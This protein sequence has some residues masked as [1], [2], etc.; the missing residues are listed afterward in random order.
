M[1]VQR[2]SSVAARRLALVGD[3]AHAFPPIGAQGLNL[4][5]RDVAAIVAEAKVGG[6]DVLAR[7]AASRRA[8][9]AMRT[10]GVGLLNSVLLTPWTPV[11][12]ARGLGLAALSAF[13]PLRKMA[14]R[15]GLNPFLAR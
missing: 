15:E 3:A 4:G 12:A 7:Y 14:M 6:E 11:D 10:L 13:A 2:V 8:D 5:L 9:I 1:A